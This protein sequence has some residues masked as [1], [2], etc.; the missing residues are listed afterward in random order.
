MFCQLL[1]LLCLDIEDIWTKIQI[2][3]VEFS[4]L[5]QAGV[6]RKGRVVKRLE[7]PITGSICGGMERDELA[8]AEEKEH[9][10]MQQDLK[11]EQ[12]K[13]KKNALES[14]VYEMRD[15]VLL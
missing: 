15:K 12:T 5:V 7:I 1:C 6:A 10:L 8:K 13:D 11:M 2:Y 4:I 3:H 14:Y 9:S